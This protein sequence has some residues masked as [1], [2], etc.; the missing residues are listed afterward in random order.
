MLL[1]SILADTMRVATRT[2][3]RH[4]PRP[5]EPNK[6]RARRRATARTDS[7]RLPD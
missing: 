5:A 2:D 4:H 7:D 1:R 3:A 6:P